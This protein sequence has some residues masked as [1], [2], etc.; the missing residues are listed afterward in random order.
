MKLLTT[1][2]NGQGEWGHWVNAGD[3]VYYCHIDYSEF[4]MKEIPKAAGFTFHGKKQPDGSW[5]GKKIWWTK[6]KDKAAKLAEYAITP[7]LQKDLMDL[8]VQ[9]TVSLA[10]SRQ[11]VGFKDF[12]HPEGLDYFP[13][14]KA[15]IE[16]ME[17]RPNTLLGDDMGLGKTIQAL[18]LINVDSSINK[19]LVICPATL[20]SNWKRE[21]E[22]WLI[23][24]MKVIVADSAKYVP[25]PEHGYNVIITNYEMVGKIND[26][27]ASV[28][29]DLLVIDEAHYIKNNR[30]IRYSSIAGGIYQKSK[31]DKPRE[32]KRITAKR[33]I[34]ATGTPVCNRPAELWPLISFLDPERWNQKTFY[35]FHKRYCNASNNGYGM[36]FKGAAGQDRLE[37]L[38]QKLRETILIRRL[39]SEVLTEL[40]PKIRQVIELEYDEDDINVRAALDREAAYQKMNEDEMQE[41]AIR[42]E[43]AKASDNDDEY[44]KAIEAMSYQN[45]T[46]FEEMARIRR[47]TAI[48]KIPY[49]LEFLEEQLESIPKIIV[50]AHHHEVIEAIARK[51][52][53]ESVSIY[54][55]VAVDKRQA[56][57]DRFQDDPN[58]RIAA[59]SIMAGGVGITLTAASYEYF[60]ELDWVPGNMTQA[61]DRAHR[62]GQKDTVNVFHLVLRDSLDVKMANTLIEKQAII[63]ATLDK[64]TE[65]EP[66]V[67]TRD[68]AAT[69]N[70]TRKK[71]AEEAEKLDPEV[72]PVIHDCL[73][74]LAGMDV[75]FARSEN[76][77]GYNKI[78]SRIGHDLSERAFLSPKQ[79]VL[80]K[81]IIKKYKKQLPAAMYNEVFN[82][83][84]KE[85]Y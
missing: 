83:A 41:A 8:K 47:D 2:D 53:L 61:E 35:Y 84:V 39:K 73:K 32:F 15:G 34:A 60:L 65:R 77:M 16:Y 74:L 33:T 72:I 42:I 79:A 19:V 28:D 29:W 20:K 75:D 38:Q 26:K 63:E 59:V 9:Q 82:V 85:E 52:P 50:F 6:D 56:A 45:K 43:L 27:L 1:I 30:T 36:D 13:F 12:P 44:K 4:G 7:E 58:C 51:W 62:I 78:D 57:V 76:G 21:A 18:G 17:V 68:N 10:Q 54:G 14:Q 49:A 48:A 3:T 80:G 31:K 23:R 70:L 46:H 11:S 22:K 5:T 69:K 67:M 71:V 37:E 64:V 81:R 66:I 24:P 55:E 40:P 25:L